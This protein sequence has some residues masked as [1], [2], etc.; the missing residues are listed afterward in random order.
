MI[1]GIPEI[2]KHFFI[3]YNGIIEVKICYSTLEA[4]S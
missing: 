4:Y 3:N 2:D 1:M